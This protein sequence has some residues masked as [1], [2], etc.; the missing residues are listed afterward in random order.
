MAALL[1]RVRELDTWQLFHEVFSLLC[2]LLDD[3]MASEA[4]NDFS[5]YL[6]G[7]C[8]RVHN[9]LSLGF[10]EPSEELVGACLK[11]MKHLL[12]CSTSK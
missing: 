12:L 6:V 1:F 3:K 5:T 4:G 8:E 2:M 7:A 11:T 9:S 10:S